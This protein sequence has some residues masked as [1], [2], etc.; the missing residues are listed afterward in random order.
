MSCPFGFSGPKVCD[1]DCDGDVESDDGLNALKGSPGKQHA[2]APSDTTPGADRFDYNKNPVSW[3]VED[4]FFQNQIK[5]EEEFQARKAELRAA[6]RKQLDEVFEK[7]GKH[8][9]VDSDDDDFSICSSEISA[10]GSDVGS[11]GE[12]GDLAREWREDA[13]FNAPGEA[14]L[15]LA[16]VVATGIAAHC[17]WASMRALLSVN[18]FWGIINHGWVPL[19]SFVSS[20]VMVAIVGACWLV[21]GRSRK[22]SIL[23]FQIGLQL[24]YVATTALALVSYTFPSEIDHKLKSSACTP[25]VGAEAAGSRL[26]QYLPAIEDE[27]KSH[28]ATLLRGCIAEAV[29]CA[30]CLALSSWYLWELSFVE[31]KALKLKRRRR[32]RKNRAR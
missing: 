28:V 6:A 21:M 26:C 1:S 27:V 12:L 14:M 9:I 24:L 25:R 29:A 7:K 10:W 30:L 4:W 15:Q 18:R 17:A 20:S 5:C 8:L 31:K 32:H 22:R 3:Y 16:L 13:H 23:G 2:N 19:A 11:I